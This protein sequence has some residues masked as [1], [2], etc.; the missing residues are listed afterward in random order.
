M[1]KVLKDLRTHIRHNN[2]LSI[3]NLNSFLVLQI[4]KI[5]THQLVLQD[6]TLESSGEYRCQITLSGVPFD[7]VQQDKNL[8][9][10]GKCSPS[11][12]CSLLY[13]LLSQ[14]SYIM[15]M[16]NNGIKTF[17][18]AITIRYVVKIYYLFKKLVNK[19]NKNA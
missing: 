3:Y 14:I 15:V 2:L 12:L 16:T 17:T 6:V 1:S 4:L 5:G 9:V 11:N 8:S 19:C 10:I 13:S 18:D 7:T